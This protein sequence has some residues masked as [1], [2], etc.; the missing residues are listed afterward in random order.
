MIILVPC[1]INVVGAVC[2]SIY[3]NQKSTRYAVQYNIALWRVRVTVVVTGTQ[4]CVLC[5][6]LRYMLRNNVECCT[7]MVLWR[8][9]FASNNK[10]YCILNI[11]CP[12]FWQILTKFAFSRW[13]YTK[14]PNMSELSRKSVQWQALCPKH[15]EHIRSEIKQQV[16]S[17]W[18]FILQIELQY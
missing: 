3:K 18:S 14:V 16:A 7:K 4:Q 8:I 1:I 17:S 13:V 9:Y 5:L 6:L 2:E 15:V 10:S 12:I 11:K